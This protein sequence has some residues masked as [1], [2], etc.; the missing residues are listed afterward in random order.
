[1]NRWWKVIVLLLLL[2]SLVSTWT[3]VAGIQRW[4]DRGGR[5]TDQ[6]GQRLCE[7]VKALER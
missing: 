1:M 6:D 4:I 2:A 5:F 3:Q 7:R